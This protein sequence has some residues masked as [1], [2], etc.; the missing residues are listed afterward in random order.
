MY[1][2][3]IP[4]TKSV[5]PVPVWIHSISRSA[6]YLPA[7]APPPPRPRCFATSVV[8]G[9]NLQTSLMGTTECEMRPGG[10]GPGVA[11][12]KVVRLSSAPSSAP[13]PGIAPSGDLKELANQWT[14]LAEMS[15]R[16]ERLS[17]EF[18]ARQREVEWKE[19]TI[20]QVSGQGYP[21]CSADGWGV[22]HKA[23]VSDCLPLA[24]PIGLSP[25]LILTICG[26][27]RVLVVSTEP[28]DDLSCLTTPGVG[29]PRDGAV[30]RAVDQVHPDG[31]GGSAHQHSL[32]CRYEL[33]NGSNLQVRW[34]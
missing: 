21:E 29:C 30:A 14:N 20:L 24:A 11:I 32:W 26:P 28:P 23:S 9:G 2:V 19:K 25:L 16:L 22:W 33:R 5:Y 31:W 10:P 18:A 12:L 13:A 15:D 8:V 3:C 6:A 4:K 34:L 7:P 17:R 27:E 1:P